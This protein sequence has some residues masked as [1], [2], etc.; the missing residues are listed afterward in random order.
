MEDMVRQ[1]SLGH[2]KSR[3]GGRLVLMPVG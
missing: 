2:E 1:A 3:P